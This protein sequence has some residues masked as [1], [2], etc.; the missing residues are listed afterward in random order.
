MRPA[1]DLFD[2]AKMALFLDVDGTLLPIRDDPAAV[3]ADSALLALLRQCGDRLDGAL[4]LVSGRA[5]TDIDRIFA[6][7]VFPAAGAH[8]AELRLHDARTASADEAPLPEHALLRLEE[9]VARHQNLLLEH[10]RGGASLHYRR[11][12]ALESACRALVN[13]ILDELGDTYRL[14]AGKMVFEIAPRMHNKGAAIEQFL[15]SQP[16][17]GRQPVFI[18]DDVTDEDGFRVA[19]ALDGMSIR[20]GENADSAAR[21]TLATVADVIPWLQ[22]AILGHKTTMQNGDAHS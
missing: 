14:I 8:G 7:E 11:A 9:F 19:N 10:K 16:F 1:P 12:P 4:A 21:Y 5:I 2:A 6:P 18:G 15:A 22:D 17:I 3:V 20:V 13:D